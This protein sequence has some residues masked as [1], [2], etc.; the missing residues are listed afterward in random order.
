MILE[1]LGVKKEVFF[2]LQEKAIA[3][4]E[5]ARKSIE[6]LV[7]VL[8]QHQLCPAFRL[9]LILR[10]LAVKGL[11]LTHP[12]PSKVLSDS[13]L[14]KV[15]HCAM[16]TVNR[17]IKFRARIPVPNAWN[18]VG[19]ADEGP[20][21]RERTGN[22]EVFCLPEGEIFGTFCLYTVR[23]CVDFI[24]PSM[25]PNGCAFRTGLSR[26]RLCYFP[27]PNRSSRGWLV[28]PVVPNVYFVLTCDYTVQRVYARGR[29]PDNVLCLFRDL[30]NC[31]VLPSQ[32]E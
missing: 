11:D 13:F 28:M 29:P 22:Q 5:S 12:S 26:R 20:A 19:V 14:S 27:Q 18:L 8:K 4:V 3:D 15:I 30:K 25:H 16:N 9:P 24:V 6:L 2:S 17:D 10:N 7:A 23:F 32:G 1:D 31:V 21:Y